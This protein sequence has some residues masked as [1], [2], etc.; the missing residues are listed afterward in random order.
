MSNQTK[1][2]DILLLS[3]LTMK[4]KLKTKR[5]SATTLCSCM[6]C[7]MEVFKPVDLSWRSY[8]IY[9]TTQVLRSWSQKELQSKHTCTHQFENTEF[10]YRRSALKLM[11]SH[12]WLTS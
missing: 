10:I 7:Y 12:L 1:N 4:D 2:V 6:I 3:L 8:F 9:W 11:T 5:S